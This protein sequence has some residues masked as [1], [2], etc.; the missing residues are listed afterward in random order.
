MLKRNRAHNALRARISRGLIFITAAMKAAELARLVAGLNYISESER[1]FVVRRI[2]ANLD[3][4]LVLAQGTTGTGLLENH[5]FDWMEPDVL[6]TLP[7]ALPLSQAQKI[8]KSNAIIRF[9]DN[10]LDNGNAVKM[11]DSPVKRLAFLGRW[12]GGEWIVL[13]AEIIET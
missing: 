4:Y 6:T 8:A 9:F 3:P 10:Q 2:A 7:P 12:R 5:T 11:G 13:Q 1:P